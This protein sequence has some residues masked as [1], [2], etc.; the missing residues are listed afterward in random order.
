MRYSRKTILI[1]PSNPK[2]KFVKVKHNLPAVDKDRLF[3]QHLVLAVK[4]AVK[5]K[6]NQTYE[7]QS[8]TVMFFNLDQAGKSNLSYRYDL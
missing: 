6:K 8:N 5:I 2:H 1:L 3:L 4:G 7:T